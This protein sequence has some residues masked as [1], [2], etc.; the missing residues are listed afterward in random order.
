MVEEGTVAGETWKIK[1]GKNEKGERK[2]E[3]NYIK[4]GKK[5][6]K[7]IFLGYKLQK[8]LRGFPPANLFIGEKNEA[9]MRGEWEWSKCTTYIPVCWPLKCLPLTSP[10]CI[11]LW[12][13]RWGLPIFRKNNTQYCILIFILN[14]SV[15][16]D[17]QLGSG[18]TG[19]NPVIFVHELNNLTLWGIFF[20]FYLW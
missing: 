16:P 13:M 5:A 1:R 19:Q 4:T 18:V 3:D 6:L 9:Q 12:N 10:L 17:A 8:F 7:F 2:R 20:F 14:K 15:V 11:L